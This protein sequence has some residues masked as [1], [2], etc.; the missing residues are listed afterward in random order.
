MT[1]ETFIFELR[2]RG[3]KR[4]ARDIRR[5]GQSANQVR[6]TL[7][8]LRSALV[9]VASVRVFAGLV[10]AMADF[11]DAMA[12]VRA[13]TGATTAQF[14]RMRDAA[15]ELGATTR[16]TAT[17]AAEGML[18]LG[19]AGFS[20]S[21][22][23]E[24]I[25]RTLAL[26]QA[27]ALELGKASEI[28]AGALRAFG[29]STQD[30]ERVVDVFTFTANNS[31]NTVLD[32]GEAMRSVAPVASGLGITIEELSAALGTLGNVNIR[33]GL[34]GR[35]LR[36]VITD[37][38]SPTG[39]LA[40][41]L[42][43]LGIKQEEVRISSV[44]FAEALKVLADA[45]VGAT[46]AARA[47]GK[48][49]AAIF[50]TLA[51]NL[52]ATDKFSAALLR[53]AGITKK[54]AAII[55]DNLK[56]ALFKTKSALEAVL[57]ALGDLGTEAF[58]QQFFE[59]LADVLR[60][61]ARNIDNVVS[62]LG[63]LLKAFLALKALRLLFFL[64]NLRKSF[65]L[66][67]RII[68]RNPLGLLATAIAGVTALMTGFQRQLKLTADGAETVEDALTV[69][70]ELL[71]N[72]V[73]QAVNGLGFEFEDFQDIVDT[74]VLNVTKAFVFMLK[75]ISGVI[76]A[77][78]V[79]FSQDTK[80]MVQ[81][82]D[83]N[84]RVGVRRILNFF[85]DET[86]KLLK[87]L[88]KET[89]FFDTTQDQEFLAA[90]RAEVKA[91]TPDV[92]TMGNAFDEIF[93]T[94]DERVQKARTFRELKEFA[95]LPDEFFDPTLPFVEKKL[96][97][98]LTPEGIGLDEV[99]KSTEQ[100]TDALRNLEAAQFP[101]LRNLDAELKILTTIGEAVENDIELRVEAEELIRRTTR[102]QLG[103][104]MSTEQLAEEI[105][106]LNQLRR[107]GII[108]MKEEEALIRKVTIAQ[109]EQSRDAGDGIKRAFLKLQD[110]ATN[111]AK[112]TEKVF[113]DAFEAVSEGITNM[114]LGIEQDF[115]AFIRNLGKQLIKLGVQ[116]ALLAGIGSITGQKSV[117]GGAGVRDLTGTLLKSIF[118]GLGGLF[119]GPTALQ[120]SGPFKHGGAFKVGAGSSLQ[121]VPGIDNRLVAFRAR[122]GEEVTVTPK[123]SSGGGSTNIVFN[124]VA[125]D[126]NSFLRSQSQLQNR[127]LAGI[128]QAR[129][130]R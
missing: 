125:R 95:D 107:E 75:V 4:S 23:I 51:A 9:V 30:A 16:F 65:G 99:T 57:L 72:E 11:A 21:E 110:D 3:A 39:D 102:A 109:L 63:V 130:K 14:T 56:G 13:V 15:K 46:L 127:A 17:E 91:L 123:N 45:G 83:A 121:S 87:D 27:G 118:S 97:P 20:T 55:D 129:K 105:K 41:I 24:T 116:Q 61:I 70:G 67:F 128:A 18:A 89:N 71:D 82:L 38:E 117:S 26:A 122:D 64:L 69:F 7:A 74:M 86:N 114:I 94:F 78:K 104:G 50:A 124:V 126:V 98:G 53:A 2:T 115:G 22:I 108:D 58:L 76:A 44:G 77:L 49:G 101:V 84:L 34:A 93:D 96:K 31:L 54:T 42:D 12:T 88:G 47:F 119:G 66:L 1:T 113:T 29:L 52:D 36:R 25:P 80:S 103:L 92:K 85:K 59:G 60:A 6:K 40:K 68:A 111:A 73:T 48:R 8:F 33:A 79:L 28:T 106:V 35:G 43:K 37:L 10:G 62:A 81:E 32:L 112:F 90:L 120:L 5:I 100:L 19:R